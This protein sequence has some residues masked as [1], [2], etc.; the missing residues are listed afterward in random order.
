[1][2]LRL[3]Q[4]VIAP[5]DYIWHNLIG[6]ELQNYIFERANRNRCRG[7]LIQ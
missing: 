2:N 6:L 5:P 4:T 1:M 3:P 7:P